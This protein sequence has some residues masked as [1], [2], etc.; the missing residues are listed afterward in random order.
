MAADAANETVSP[1]ARRA[2]PLRLALGICALTIFAP[3]FGRA[4]QPVTDDEVP[5][6]GGPAAVRRLLG[7]D[8]SR[9]ASTFFLD[10]HEVLVFAVGTHVGWKDVERRRTVVDFAEDVEEWKKTFGASAV[11]STAAADW[12]RTR[13]ALEWIGIHVRGDPRVFTMER[14]DDARSLRRQACLEA[15]GTATPALIASLKG[16]ERVTISA[17]D[18]AAP[19]AQRLVRWAPSRAPAHE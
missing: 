16:G 17:A 1:P 11:L 7:L 19:T 6:P 2:L 18:G 10:V 13:A 15:L 14:R 4:D 9:P 8:P 12:N 5:V 3:A